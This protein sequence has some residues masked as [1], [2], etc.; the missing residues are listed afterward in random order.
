[1][2]F[3]KPLLRAMSF[4]KGFS[5]VELLVAI[6]LAMLV[7]ALIM[8]AV[9]FIRDRAEAIKCGNNLRQ[10]Q[11]ALAAAIQDKGQ[12]P[13]EPKYIWESNNQ[14]LY[15]DWWLEELKPYGIIEKSWQCPTIYR[16]IS[17]KAKDGRPKLHYTPTRFDDK[18]GTPYKWPKQPWLV[19][20]GNMHGAG[21]L[22]AFPDGSTRA[23]NEVLSSQ[24][25]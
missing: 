5:L 22:M 11:V 8:T 1:V 4:N 9:P 17:S 12:W 23:I 15:E 6:V 2:L 14:D 24:G 16:K 21:A 25:Q 18:P 19:E 20:I 10:L 13:Q 3:K 7:A